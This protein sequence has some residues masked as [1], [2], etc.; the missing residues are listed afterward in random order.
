MMDS[1]LSVRQINI[2][3]Y[4][5]VLFHVNVS[6]VTTDG[7][8]SK[9]W[10]QYRIDF[11]PAHKGQHGILQSGLHLN[12]VKQQIINRQLQANRIKHIYSAIS[13]LNHFSVELNVTVVC[14]G[15]PFFYSLPAKSYSYIY[16]YIYIATQLFVS[17]TVFIHY[18]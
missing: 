14:E 5:W 4:L 13:N 3:E 9:G 17:S 7:S 18:V 1:G 12:A 15:Q 11:H 2:Q 8:L 16:I 6:M 10:W